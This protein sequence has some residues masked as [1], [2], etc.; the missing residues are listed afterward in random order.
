M[1]F[2]GWSGLAAAARAARS[3]SA[4]DFTSATASFRGTLELAR[5]HAPS[6]EAFVEWRRDNPGEPLVIGGCLEGWPLRDWG[7]ER[8]RELDVEVPLEMSRGGGDYRDAFRDDRGTYAERELGARAFVAGHPARLRDFVDA[9]LL[10]DR[11]APPRHL[12]AYLAQHDLLVRVPELAEACA[13]IPPYVGRGDPRDDDDATPTPDRRVWL[14]PSGTV[15]PL[16]RDPY[17]N[18]LCQAW[19]EKRVLMFRAQDSDAMYPFSGGFLRNASRVDAEA[20]DLDAHPAFATVPR[21]ETSLRPGEMLFMPAR[22]WHHVRAETA[23]LSL[24]H[25]WGRG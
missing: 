24:S 18:L 17:H 20:P 2:R 7:P 8:L 23:S 22:L 11:D 6:V 14:G 5:L 13:D 10:R 21:W 1:R 9:F 3:R 15:T 4:R 16:H 19:G 25:W 12:T